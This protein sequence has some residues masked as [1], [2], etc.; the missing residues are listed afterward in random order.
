MDE[1][2]GYKNFIND[3][4]RIKCN[5][6]N[7]ARNAY[8]NYS[9]MILYYAKEKDKQIWNNIREPMSEEKGENFSRRSIPNMAI[10]QQIQS[11]PREK[12]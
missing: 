8:G 6:K 9:D 5:P 7:F 12:Q 4:T 2:F 1:V 10:T 3:I 11:T